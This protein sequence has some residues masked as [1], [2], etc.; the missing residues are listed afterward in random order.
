MLVPFAGP[1]MRETI[2]VYREAC[3][4]AGHSGQGRIALG[5]HMFCQEDR[6]ETRR[7]A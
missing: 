4:E 3:R 6:E 5:F 2:G 7:T 1:Q